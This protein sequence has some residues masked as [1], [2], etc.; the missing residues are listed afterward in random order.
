MKF[1]HSGAAGDLVF[2]LPVIQELSVGQDTTIYLQQGQHFSDETIASLIPLLRSQGV[3][4]EP[5]HHQEYDIDLDDFRSLGLNYNCGHVPYYYSYA[6]HAWPDL[7]QPWLKL[8]NSGQH[9]NKIIVNKTCRYVPNI[10]LECLREHKQ[11]YFLGHDDEYELFKRHCPEGGRIKVS[12]HLQMAEAINGC[13]LFIGNQSCAY[14]IAEGLGTPRALLV[15]RIGQD[16]IPMTPMGYA[17]W[18]E[19]NLL[20]V[21]RHFGFRR[22]GHELR[23]A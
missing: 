4:A 22:E 11:V 8:N 1:K 19:K 12:N 18:T 20:N 6:H 21:L 3:Q 17:C 13:G 15:P 10:N 14:A 7:T 5:Y 9:L 23:K 16:V 2:A